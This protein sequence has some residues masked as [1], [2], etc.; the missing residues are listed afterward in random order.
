MAAAHASFAA[1]SQNVDPGTEAAPTDPMMTAGNGSLVTLEDLGNRGRAFIS[2]PPRRRDRRL[3]GRG[4]TA[5][6]AR[7]CRPGVG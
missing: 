1:A 4:G 5:A 7:P 2:R 6:R 3:S